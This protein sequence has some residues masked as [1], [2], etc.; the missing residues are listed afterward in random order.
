MKPYF[1][2]LSLISAIL[3]GC[4][5]TQKSTP[6]NKTNQ[7]KNIIESVKEIESEDT[8]TEKQEKKKQVTRRKRKEHLL[9]QFE[10]NKVKYQIFSTDSISFDDDKDN[11]YKKLTDSLK[12]LN[13]KLNREQYIKEFEKAIYKKDS[14]KVY[15]TKDTV[16]IQLDNGKV[17]TIYAYDPYKKNDLDRYVSDYF[18][19]E[20]LILIGAA[21]EEAGHYYLIDKKTGEQQ[22][23]IGKPIFSPNRK[24][25]LSFS[26]NIDTGLSINGIQLIQFNN[27]TL[28]ELCY[29]EFGSIEPRSVKWIDDNTLI[30]ELTRYVPKIIIK[31]SIYD[32]LDFTYYKVKFEVK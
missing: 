16:K 27:N 5:R 30:L 17:K 31:G 6:N 12:K 20:N 28:K 25:I 7:Q 14:I 10:C 8:Q 9:S 2:I 26:G 18:P 13:P 22:M 32:K 4:D 21:I 15:R 1:I 29:Y 24:L 19:D 3:F 11:R 23:L